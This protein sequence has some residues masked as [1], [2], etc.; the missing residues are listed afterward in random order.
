MYT[1]AIISAL[2]VQ[3]NSSPIRLK[4]PNQ[5][6]TYNVNWRKNFAKSTELIEDGNKGNQTYVAL[7]QARA[8][9]ASHDIY[10]YENW[11]YGIKN[12]I[13][14]ESGALDGKLFSTSHMFE[15][16]ANWTAIHVEADL[17]NYQALCSNRQGSLNINCALCDIP[18]T[19]HYVSGHAT[20]Q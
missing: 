11:F 13:I 19:L 5:L 17:K 1:L 18:T 10:A 8:G 14:V 7:A 20:G 15:Y 12:G 16:Y 4:Y 2:F 6:F 9:D 3:I